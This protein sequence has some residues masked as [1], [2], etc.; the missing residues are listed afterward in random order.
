[1]RKIL[2]ASG[3][4]VMVVMA[5]TNVGL[6]QKAGAHLLSEPVCTISG[7]TVTCTGGSAAG[8]GNQPVVVSASVDA[9]CQ[10]RPG[11]NEPAGHTQFTSAPIQPKGGRIDFPT[12]TLSPDCPGGLNPVIGN[13]VT[14]TILT[15]G[16]VLVFTFTVTAT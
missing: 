1:M 12:I 8:L 16:G 5:V 4:A 6:A 2:W 11:N 13:I 7:G 15:E 10:T 14:Y 3:L 9:G